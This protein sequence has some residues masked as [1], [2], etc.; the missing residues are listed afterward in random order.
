LNVSGN[1]S[2]TGG[3]YQVET[4][5]A[6]QSDKILAT[7]TATL[8][9]GT[10]QVVSPAGAY[11]SAVTYRILTA[12]GGV[13][14]A[15]SGGTDNLAFL[16]ATLSYDANNV[17]LNLSRN[18]TFFQDQALTRNQRAAAG[19]LDQFPTTNPLFLAAASLGRASIPGALDSLSGEIHASLQSTLVD[20][21]LFVRDALEGRLR[22][23]SFAGT[24]GAM[25]ALGIGGPAF[26]YTDTSSAY[27]SVGKSGFPVKAAPL[28]A[29]PPASDLTWWSQGI[30][31]WGR[32]SG[33]G[34]AADVSRSLAGFFTGVDRRYGD[35]WRLGVAGGY[36]NSSVNMNARAS[37]A[38]IDTAHLAAYAGADYGPLNFRSGAAFA[39][40]TI[41]TSR[42]ILFPGFIDNATAHYGASTSQLFGEVGYARA[43]G[44]LAVEPFAGLAYVHLDTGGFTEAGGGAA[45]AGSRV[46]EDVGYSSL[47]L[48]IAESFALV[49]G[50]SIVPR[51]SAY[52][53]H[54]YSDVTPTTALTFLSTG[55]S[56]S[57]AGV[58]LARDAAI[59]ESGFDLQLSPR[60]KI[61]LSYFG[62]LATHLND[63]AVKGKFTWNF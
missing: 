29:Q 20:D 59:V 14:G 1:V 17:F 19:A 57:V 33:D 8:S 9:G 62:E 48:R 28:A 7:G 35:N 4:N 40:N 47:G 41:G 45:L 37:A 55:V 50:M 22:Q 23:A 60:A 46:T 38:N 5:L 24:G 58:P 18:P 21:S 12:N 63:H 6:G 27:A 26:A 49:N 31:A 42:T 11:S 52:W 2:F 36:T 43:F 15:F 16:T 30:G 61:G 13:S 54:A 44:N 25:A 34:N 56:F 3:V 39:W 32:I 53:Q 51:V 10:V